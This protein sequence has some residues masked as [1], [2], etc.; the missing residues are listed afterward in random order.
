[1]QRGD[2]RVEDDA[3]TC[4]ASADSEEA[5]CGGTAAAWSVPTDC[6]D[7]TESGTSSQTRTLDPVYHVLSER[8]L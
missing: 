8:S 1:M 3:V 2:E 4:G 5:L 6:C 7:L